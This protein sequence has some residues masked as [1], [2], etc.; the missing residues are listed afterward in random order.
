VQVPSYPAAL[1][2]THLHEDLLGPDALGD[3][4]LDPDEVGHASIFVPYGVDAE[5]IPEQGTVLTV[6]PEQHG[7]APPLVY[8]GP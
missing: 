7:A 3:V 1:C 8:R 5:L 2:L 4:V 6:V